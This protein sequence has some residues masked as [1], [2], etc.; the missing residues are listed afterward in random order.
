MGLSR[1]DVDEAVLFAKVTEFFW[2]FQLHLFIRQ[3]LIFKSC[4]RLFNV[5]VS[6]I[7]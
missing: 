2:A 3:F 7:Y 6:Y 4:I 5:T 1:G